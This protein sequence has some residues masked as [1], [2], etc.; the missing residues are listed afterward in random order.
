MLSP[1]SSPLDED[2]TISILPSYQ[3]D[4]A[5]LSK[6]IEL[7]REM[8]MPI[9]SYNQILSGANDLDSLP[10]S[11]SLST[12]STNA[13]VAATQVSR[14]LIATYLPRSSNS[15]ETRFFDVHHQL[16]R[17]S[18]NSSISLQIQTDNGGLGAYAQGDD[19]TGHI[20]VENTSNVRIPFTMIYI[21]LEGNI[22]YHSVISGHVTRVENFLRV[23]DLAAS[24][25]ADSKI[26]FGENN[27]L[28]PGATYKKHFLFK[29]PPSLLESTCSHTGLAA[30][31]ELPCLIPHRPRVNAKH[32]N[33][34]F[35]TIS[36]TY[37]INA[38][39]ISPDLT[40]SEYVLLQ[41]VKKHIDVI[42]LQRHQTNLER[43]YTRS[44]IKYAYHNLIKRLESAIPLAQDRSRT[45]SPTTSA[46]SSSK[47]DHTEVALLDDSFIQNDTFV[48]TTAY[49]KKCA[50]SSN[51]KRIGD[52]TVEI[53]IETFSV[54]Y[55]QPGAPRKPK[56]REAW[57]VCVP[58]SMKF[59]GTKKSSCLPV[60]KDVS[61]TLV[62][63]SVSAYEKD[64]YIPLELG[65]ELI[66]D[67]SQ[68][69]ENF[70][71][72]VKQRFK[73][74]HKRLKDHLRQ[75]SDA[76]V[77][78]ELFVDSESLANLRKK[79]FELKLQDVKMTPRNWVPSQDH[80]VQEFL[81]SLDLSSATLGPAGGKAYDDFNMIPS[82]QNC[83]MCRLYYV[84]LSLVFTNGTLVSVKVPMTITS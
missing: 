57:V 21:F 10:E 66:F 76:T 49:Y 36:I 83:T 3:M 20:L 72:I 27:Y 31:L 65:H 51:G 40:A 14:D 55:L 42:P 33:L 32:S 50:L 9:P 82:F 29:I 78:K 15:V 41:E 1:D 28:Q 52:L 77:D 13:S 71:T 11:L 62:A 22:N 58:V 80:Y 81:V 34:G 63:V 6:S 56:D 38:K 68:P 25:T 17:A 64:Q 7:P 75:N 61:A 70:D 5:I 84:K 16:N 54:K 23:V 39:C 18:C 67:N 69:Q 19:V 73:S 2:N 46:D 74:L 45:A 8:A 37:D 12:V 43:L 35:S 44:Q 47:Y 53:P 30:H 59:V 48:T 60:I 4:Q 79:D 26:F 24:S